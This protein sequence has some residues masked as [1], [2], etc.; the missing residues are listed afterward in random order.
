MC[1]ARRRCGRWISFFF[2]S[3]SLPLSLCSAF[4]LFLPS[5]GVSP[6][7]LS[8]LGFGDYLCGMLFYWRDETRRD[9]VVVVGVAEWE[10]ERASGVDETT[11]PARGGAG[12]GGC[13]SRLVLGALGERQ[14]QPGSRRVARHRAKPKCRR[15]PRRG[16]GRSKPS[17][18]H[19]APPREAWRTWSPP[20]RFYY[21]DYPPSLSPVLAFLR[22][23]LALVRLALLQRSESGARLATATATPA[24]R[25][26]RFA[27]HRWSVVSV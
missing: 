1:S 5:R 11:G 23:L 10:S 2:F 26:R 18:P 12:V 8:V 17:Q 20:P 6:L 7:S 24:L 13:C 22:Y 19:A 21:C 16:Q 27:W 14:G 3:F 9:G 25:R 15:V 4:F